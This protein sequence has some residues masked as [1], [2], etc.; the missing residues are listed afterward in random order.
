MEQITINVP[1]NYPKDKLKEKI[2]KL[3]TDLKKRS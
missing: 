1:D 2:Q 3:E